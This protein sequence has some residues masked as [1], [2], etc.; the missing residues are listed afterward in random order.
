M[1]L[2]VM[3]I[4]HMMNNT[5]THTTK[6]LMEIGMVIMVLCYTLSWLYT[7]YSYFGSQQEPSSP[8]FAEGSDVRPQLLQSSILSN[9]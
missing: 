6:T 1:L 3:G 7:I 4:I 9:D 2:V 5:E 8:A